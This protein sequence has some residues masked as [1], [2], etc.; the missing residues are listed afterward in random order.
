M[1]TYKHL[2]YKSR[3]T[4][5]VLFNQ[6]K[7]IRQI[8]EV[9]NVNYSTIYRELKKGEYKHRNSNYT[10]R[11]KYSSDIAHKKYRDN[12]KLKGL[13]SKVSRD[14]R[15]LNY[16][17]KEIKN[18]HSPA[19]I[20]TNIKN[21]VLSNYISVCTKTIY[22]YIDKGMIDGISNIDLIE[23]TK[24]R[25]KKT[26]PVKRCSRDK[27]FGI[28]IEER[29]ETIESRKVCGHWE[30]DCVMGKKSD[31]Y[32]LLVISERKSRFEKIFLI[33]KHTAEEVNKQIY[34]LK[35]QLGEKFYK[36][37]KTITCD[38]GTEFSRLYQ[39]H[40]NVY[41]CHPYSPY[42]RGTNENINKMIRRFFPKGQQIRASPKKLKY[43][44][45]YINNYPRKILGYKSAAEVF[46]QNFPLF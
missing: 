12:L 23:K 3:V 33:K 46:S 22:N 21:N 38:N 29:P 4:I 2:T 45:D 32:C 6:K 10:Y 27:S 13:R 18:K 30:I 20:A 35:K 43:V 8:A 40:K 14:I 37:F 42:E 25:I 1:K 19:V 31:P 16:I 26:F 39:V 24:R 41:Y 5:E 11:I 17:K 15:L 44:E 9:L 36:V 28:G 34:K 7:S